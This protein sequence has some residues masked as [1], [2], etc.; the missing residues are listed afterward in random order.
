MFFLRELLAVDNIVKFKP[1]YTNQPY[2]YRH[3]VVIPGIDCIIKI[4]KTSNYA[5]MIVGR[6]NAIAFFVVLLSLSSMTVRIVTSFPTGAGGCDGGMAAV[7]GTHLGSDGRIVS[8]NTLATG[9][10][11]VAIGNITLDVNI[12]LNLSLAE[13]HIITI[14]SIE[15]PL[16]GI[17][18]RAE[19]PDGF[20]TST[21][22]SPGL[23]TKV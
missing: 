13:D 12:P 23:L 15:F 22:L 19:A 9:G 1:W 8:N 20:D 10:V 21:I 16:R 18:I 11:N 17:L 5:N 2:G 3:Y 6:M 4:L 7:G 14:D